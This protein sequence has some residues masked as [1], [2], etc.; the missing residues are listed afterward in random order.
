MPAGERFNR[1][2]V[3]GAAYGTLSWN[4]KPLARRAKDVVRSVDRLPTRE[5]GTLSF[6]N[7]LPEQPIQELWAYDIGAGKEPSGSFKLSYTID[8]AASPD[9]ASLQPLNAWIA[10]RFAPNEHA[11][12]LALPSAGVRATVGAGA[13]GAAGTVTRAK[14]AAPIVHVLI[15]ATFGDAYADKPI[16][17]AWDY[18]WQNLHDG[19]DGI[20]IDLPELKGAATIP[21]NIKVHDPLWPG[22]DVTARLLP[23]GWSP[24]WSTAGWRMGR[25]TRKAP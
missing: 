1:I 7:I 6:T 3:R 21:L 13:A 20:A 22:R 12:V 8:A 15:P 25:K 4:G 18:G 11:T 24:A 16:A 5:G 9:I 2:E 17:R 10:G 14:S 19:L 23:G